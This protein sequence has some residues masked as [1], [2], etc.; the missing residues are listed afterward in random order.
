MRHRV[1]LSGM[2]YCIFATKQQRFNSRTTGFDNTV[3]ISQTNDACLEIDYAEFC[4]LAENTIR[5][6]VG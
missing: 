6:S 3:W 1:G 5:F 4:F 2:L